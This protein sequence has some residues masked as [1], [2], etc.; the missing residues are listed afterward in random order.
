M[1]RK[2]IMSVSCSRET[3]F[4]CIFLQIEKGVF[5]L[6]LIFTSILFFFKIFINSFEIALKFIREQ[7]IIFDLHKELE[8]NHVVKDCPLCANRKNDQL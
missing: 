8:N 4:V 5:S 2:P 3:R 7:G 1:T 6:P